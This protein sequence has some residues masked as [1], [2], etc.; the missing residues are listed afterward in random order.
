MRISE[1]A[2][3]GCRCWA[4]VPLLLLAP[5]AGATDLDG[6]G[7]SVWWGAPFVGILLSIAI[8]PMVSADFWH[9]HYGKVVAGLTLVFLLPFVLVFGPGTTGG[10]LV[11]AVLTEYVPFLILLLTLYTLSGGILISG[12]LKASPGLNTRILAIGTVLAPIMGTT[13]AAMLLIRPLLRANRSRHHKVHVVVFFIFLVANIGG[14]LTPLGDPPLFL[15]FLN[16]VTFSWTFTHMLAPVVFAAAILLTVFYLVDWYYFRKEPNMQP[17]DV[18][19]EPLRLSG[20]I[21]L[22]LLAGAIAAV[23]L[24]GLWNPDMS[25]SVAGVPL[26]LQNLARDGLLLCLTAASLWLTPRYVRAANEFN[27]HPMVEVAKLFAGIFITIAPV[28]AMLR[29]GAGGP[30]AAFAALVSDP[31][32]QPSVPMYFWAT[33]VLSSVLDNAPTYLVFFN[34]ASGNPVELMGPLSSTLQAI[35]VGAVFMGAM[36]YIGNAP[37]FMIK[38]IASHHRIRMPGFFGYMLWSGL[39]LLPLFFLMTW[40][41]F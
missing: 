37:N 8:L 32:G 12:R 11:H 23:L 36:T 24:S 15:G 7:L 34:M 4:A 35:S 26:A 20:L 33:G 19:A 29:A 38:A 6:T 2:G 17:V 39:F 14:G 27:W 3:K 25:I 16:G 30:F 1:F 31:A 41:F 22:L 40:L 10:L 21:N 9:S 28:I 13:G 18:N 5:G